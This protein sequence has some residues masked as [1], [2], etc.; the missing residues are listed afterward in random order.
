M[1][2]KTAIV[3]SAV[4]ALATA[5]ANYPLFRQC[6]GSW[7]SNRMGTS[8][9][10]VCQA[11]CLISSVSMVLRACGRTVGGAAADPGSLNRWLGQNGGYV[12]GNSF[13]WGSVGSLGLGYVG[14][15]SSATDI[16][17]HFR[18]GRAVV[19]NVRNGG[20]WVLM[21]GATTAGYTVRDPGYSVTTYN[22]ADVTR[23]GVYN[24]PA[25]CP[26]HLRSENVAEEELPPLDPTE[27]E[28]MDFDFKE[29][30]EAFLQ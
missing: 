20:H 8:T 11:G 22:N 10:T 5:Q 7:G 13:V 1:F 15:T 3:L 14:Q 6:D 9:R 21:T 16:R 28:I 17:S 29:L 18:N 23:A 25:G 24:R 27:I 30:E 4:V 19:L 26:A 2:A 12:S